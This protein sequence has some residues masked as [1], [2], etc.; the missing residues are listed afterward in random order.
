MLEKKKANIIELDDLRSFLKIFSQNWH[1]IVLLILLSGVLSYFYT[2]KLPDVYAAKTQ[3]LLKSDDTYDYQSQIYKGIGYYQAYQ[4]NDNQIRVLTSNDLIG[5]A[6]SK[7][8]LDVSYFIVG[9][10]KTTEVYQSMPFEVDVVHFANNLYEK[11]IKLKI[12]D[13]NEFQISYL[14]GKDEIVKKYPFNKKIVE[15]DFIVTVR[16]NENINDKTINSLSDIDYIIKVHS[17]ENLVNKFKNALSVESIENTTILE[18][19]LEDEIPFRAITFLDTLSKVYVDYTAKAQFTIN[20]NTLSNIEKQLKEITEILDSIENNMENYKS[21]KAILDLPKEEEQYFNK[22]IDFDS[23]KRQLQLYS[24]SLGAL[25]EYIISLAEKV[26]KK[27]LPPSFY[28]EK[29]DDYMQSAL[30]KVYSMQMERNEKLFGSTEKN[31]NINE[32]DQNIELL[33]KN[34]L[35]YIVNSQKGLALQIGD[36]DKQIAE[37]TN[38]IKRIPKTERELLAIQRKVDVNEKM[39]QFLLE[40]RASTIIARSGI[41]PQTSIIESAHSVGI[42]KPNK[43]KILYYFITVAALLGL[44]ISFIRTIVF[45]TIENIN[46]LKRLTNLPVLGEIM[47]SADATQDYIIVDKDPKSSVTESF[48]SIRTNLQYMAADANSKIILITSYNPGEGKTFCSVNLATILA[49][50][51]KKSVAS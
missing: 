13:E 39:Y 24:Q 42:I 4:D 37:Y 49:K 8:K 50:A 43:R 33:K 44:I 26:D 25:E 36:L 29:G 45:S 15:S 7:I 21:N 20:E 32:L 1:I 28:I 11:D 27:L 31:R 46:E 30:S 19:S 47:F 18:L 9:R 17:P 10:L 14:N 35:T 3:I 41:L 6:L 40:K 38:I 2:Y 22:L 16:K 5:Q 48:R 12:I 23:Q 34:I 51:N